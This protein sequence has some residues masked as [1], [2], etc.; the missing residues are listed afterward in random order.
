MKSKRGQVTL[1]IIIAIVIVALCLGGYFLYKEQ[2]KKI[3]IA[4]S[5]IVTNVKSYSKDRINYAVENSLHLICFQGG[6]SKITTRHLD[7]QFYS[8][9]YYLS[10]NQTSIPDKETIK[11][12]LIKEIK[13]RLNEVSLNFSN[14]EI[15]KENPEVEVN[16]TEQTK[17]SVKF[18]ITIKKDKNIASLSNDYSYKYDLDFNKFLAISQEIASNSVNESNSLNPEFLLNLQNEYRIIISP[19]I[20]DENTIIYRLIENNTQLNENQFEFDFA[21]GK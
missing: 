8:I 17:I 14:A 5:S 13:T 3:D 18:P 19:I 16:L 2:Q 10:N 21:I 4:F 9:P 1:F 20:Y 15:N 12:E 6:Y 7:L 11:A